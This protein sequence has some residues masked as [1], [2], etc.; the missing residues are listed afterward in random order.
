M[1]EENSIGFEEFVD[2]IEALC[3][4]I[5]IVLGDRVEPPKAVQ[6]LQMMASVLRPTIP[7]VKSPLRSGVSPALASKKGPETQMDLKV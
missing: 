2:C 6:S 7:R 5:M 4:A 1:G 3:S